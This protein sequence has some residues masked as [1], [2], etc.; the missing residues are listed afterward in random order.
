M[1]KPAIIKEGSLKGN[2]HSTTLNKHQ[3]LKTDLPLS[4][5][6]EVKK[7]EDKLRKSGKKRL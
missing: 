3:E 2:M 6:D 4:E 7:A 5:K 1:K